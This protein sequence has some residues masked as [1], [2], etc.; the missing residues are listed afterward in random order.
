VA[1][2]V[3]RHD[4][5]VLVT[6]ETGSG[7]EVM[8]RYIHDS[9]S[10]SQG[11]FITVNCGAIPDQLVE[12]TL[13]GHER[14]AFTDAKE[15]RAGLFEA[16][17]G[18]TIF[19][20]EIGELSLAA[21]VRLLRVLESH[22]I[23]RVGATSA[24]KINIRVIAATHRDLEQ[25]VQERTFRQDLYFRLSAVTVPVPPLRERKEDISALIEMA[26]ARFATRT[27]MA[28]PRMTSAALD[29]ALQYEWPGN[30]RELLHVIDRTIIACSE[31]TI[32]HL[33]IRLSRQT[34]VVE[35]S[36]VAIDDSRSLREV[37]D[38][39]MEGI[40]RRYIEQVLS[41]LEGNIGRAAEHAGIHRK[42][43]YNK[44]RRYG[45]SS[46]GRS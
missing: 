38:P 37:I 14:G 39:I 33:D 27:N 12:S 28:V 29:Q 1:R 21:Q 44:M 26:L 5:S 20:D 40:E 4:I 46:R 22:E 6:G 30:V 13:F 34:P 42:S 43:L 41:R 15:R 35:T 31:D 17:N 16:S 45:L 32:S 7:K 19:L 9:S 10:R 24:L 2:N 8:A 18:G 3:A 36:E 11:P 25:M 23:T